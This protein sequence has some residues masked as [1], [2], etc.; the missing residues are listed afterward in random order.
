LGE[1]VL[2]E[3]KLGGKCVPDNTFWTLEDDETAGAKEGSKVGDTLL[4]FDR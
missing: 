3:G 2:L 1:R 4:L